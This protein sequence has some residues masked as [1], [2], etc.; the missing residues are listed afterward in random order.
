MRNS[1]GRPAEFD[2][3]RIDTRPLPGGSWLSNGLGYDEFS[4]MQ[5]QRQHTNR[6]LPT[7][8]W[9]IQ[10]HLLRDVIVTYLEHR[11]RM[12]P[13]RTILPRSINKRLARVRLWLK[14]QAPMFSADLDVTLGKR[15]AAKLAKAESSVLKK[16]DVR[17]EQLDSAIRFSANGPELTLAIAY[18]YH[19]CEIDATGIAQMVGMKPP[20]VRIVLHRLR[21]TWERHLR[22]KYESR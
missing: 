21:Q 9:A 19:R 12:G 20:A 22:A 2:L 11:T 4:S 6:K 15:M 13:R 1:Q 14:A 5:I 8:I 3:N 18:L 7:P 16:L 17:A 10:D